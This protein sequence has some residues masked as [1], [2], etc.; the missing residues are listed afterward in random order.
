MSLTYNTRD[1][2][3]NDIVKLVD[4]GEPKTVLHNFICP[5]CHMPQINGVLLKDCV[6]GYYA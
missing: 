6:S 2:K 4:L 1:G 3:G 5:L